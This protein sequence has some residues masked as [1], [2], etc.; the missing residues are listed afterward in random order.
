MEKWYLNWSTRTEITNI[1]WLEYLYYVKL[2]SSDAFYQ[3]QLPD[4][5]CWEKGLQEKDTIDPYIANYL[6]Y[7][8][9]RYYPVVGVTYEQ[10]VN[11]CKW[12]GDVV[13]KS[14][15]DSSR[16]ENAK[17]RDY[18]VSVEYRLPT[19]EEWEYAASGGL[20]IDRYPHGLKRPVNRKNYI[21]KTSEI[22][23][24][25]CLDK[26][27]IE[28]DGQTIVHRMEF[29]ALEDYYLNLGGPL[30]TCAPDTAFKL[31]YIF[32]FPPN[33]F[34][35]YNM[36]GNVA[37]MTTQKGLAKGGSFRSSINSFTIRTGFSYNKPQE[38]LGFRCV[39]IVH[40][41]RKGVEY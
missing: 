2:D 24:K 4:S 30:I 9:F 36:I 15:R 32:D 25:K 31:N 10:A 34:G 33:N 41:R 39:A 16:K 3:S 38:W 1:N 19:K 7:P 20:N 6:R 37:E 26:Q 14:L 23:I 35:L 27:K 17:I 22:G 18:E 28:Y 21:H 13:T 8:G 5:T 12:R 40:I 11:Y 29:G